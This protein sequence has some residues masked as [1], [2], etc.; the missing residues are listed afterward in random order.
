MCSL[1]VSFLPSELTWLVQIVYLTVALYRI[2]MLG[3]LYMEIRRSQRS[4]L[5]GSLLQTGEDSND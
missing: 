2:I 1:A 4:L 3:Y 5:H